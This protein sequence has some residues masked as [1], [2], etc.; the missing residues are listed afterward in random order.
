MNISLLSLLFILALILFLGDQ[1]IE[2]RIDMRKLIFG[3]FALSLGFTS[4][5]KDEFN[6][7]EEI[8]IVGTEWE[9]TGQISTESDTVNLS[10]NFLKDGLLNATYDTTAWEGTYNFDLETHK[11]IIIDSASR[12]IPF[13]IKAD[14]LKLVILEGDTIQLQKIK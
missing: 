7:Q 9:G 2:N 13:L 8:N 1:N 12:E 11:G 5:V 6:V 4:C 14:I 10:L 3:L